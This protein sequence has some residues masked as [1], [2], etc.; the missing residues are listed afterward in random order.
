MQQKT[1]TTRITKRTANKTAGRPTKKTAKKTAKKAATRTAKKTAKGPAKKATRPATKKVLDKPEQKSSTIAAEK[2]SKLSVLKK[3]KRPILVPV[4][5][6]AHSEA[7]LVFAAHLAEGLDMPLAVLHVVHDPGDAPGYYQVKGRMKQLRRLEDVAGE[8]L[9]E[10]MNR[11][12]K[13]YSKHP[14]IEESKRL[15]VTGLPVTRILEIVQALE[16]KMVVM[17]SAGR[18]AMSRFLLGSKVEQVLRMCPCP[19]TIVKIPED[20]P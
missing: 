8:L 15:L 2:L 20:K 5:F 4:D 18:T 17:G 11:M 6:S 14:A 9:G 3:G 1:T 13:K 19:V 10:F 16:P 7:A 12:V